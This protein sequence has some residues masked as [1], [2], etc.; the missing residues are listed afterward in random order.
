MDAESAWSL[1]DAYFSEHTYAFTRHHIESFRQFLR[2]N[3]P[4]TIKSYNPIT[5]VKFD[6]AGVED[7]KVEVFVGG[8]EV[9]SNANGNG[10][11]GTGIRV[12]RPTMPGPDGAPILQLP[13]EARIRDQTYQMNLVADV[14][15]RYT[16]RGV[17]LLYTSP[18][19]RDLSTSRMPSS[20]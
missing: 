8:E 1:I 10:N 15:V 2:H 18:S 11:A 13:Y 7:F 3:I 19:P 17:C 9:A 20:A 14:V 12:D 16:V 5:M 6:A 4:L